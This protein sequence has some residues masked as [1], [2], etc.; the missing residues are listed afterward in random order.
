MIFY[1]MY[2]LDKHI[3]ITNLKKKLE[4]KSAWE[5]TWPSHL[6]HHK[7]DIDRYRIELG[8]PLLDTDD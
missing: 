5:E 8:P 1:T 4:N 3:G 2:V 7:S 6:L